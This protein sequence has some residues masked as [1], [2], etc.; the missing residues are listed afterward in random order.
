[1]Y[2]Y[3]R[4]ILIG[5]Q[6]AIISIFI[7]IIYQFINKIINTFIIFVLILHKNTNLTDSKL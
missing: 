3:I 6:K 4:I 1:M 7:I 5:S 2:I